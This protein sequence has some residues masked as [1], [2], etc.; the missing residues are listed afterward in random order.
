MYT[1]KRKSR[2]KSHWNSNFITD[3]IY[4]LFSTQ[5]KEKV[6]RQKN[7]QSMMYKRQFIL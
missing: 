1:N 7:V 5:P 3:Y 4:F 2:E 6:F